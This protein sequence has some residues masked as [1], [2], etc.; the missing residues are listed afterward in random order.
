ME[1]HLF[2]LNL[3]LNHYNGKHKQN[4]VVNSDGAMC[5]VKSI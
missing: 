4:K 5:L 1:V 2:H 3:I